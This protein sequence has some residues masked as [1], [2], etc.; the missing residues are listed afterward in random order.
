MKPTRNKRRESF[1]RL[2]ILA[3]ASVAAPVLVSADACAP[4]EIQRP[5][6]HCVVRVLSVGDALTEPYLAVDPDDPDVMA[7][8][9]NTLDATMMDAPTEWRIRPDAYVTWDG[10][11]SWF[12]TRL[13]H[14][15][16]DP[17]LA[18]N[19]GV[20]HYVHNDCPGTLANVLLGAVSPDFE[21]DIRIVDDVSH[22]R[23]R[24]FERHVV[25][26]PL[27]DGAWTDRPWLT[28]GDDGTL[29]VSGRS[30]GATGDISWSRDEG[31]TWQRLP[32]G[33]RPD[34]CRSMSPV[35]P[36]LLLFACVTRSTN[37]VRVWRID[38]TSAT[39]ARVADVE[40]LD[41]VIA[42]EIAFNIVRAAGGLVIVVDS[43]ESET[44]LLARSEDGGATWG[45]ATDLSDHLANRSGWTHFV[46]RWMAAGPDGALHLL[47]EFEAATRPL[48]YYDQGDGYPDTTGV[49][50]V[51]LDPITLEVR[52]ERILES[53]DPAEKW[54]DVPGGPTAWLAL[55][56]DAWG[57]AFN[58]TR[59]VLAYQRNGGIDV[60]R[61]IG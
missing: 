11:S 20:L 50:Y 60:F 22:D 43:R 23:G 35:E 48:A 18:F 44:V 24:T 47:L 17:T 45:P 16:G 13:M 14:S 41:D 36:S 27:A 46:K 9:T 57:I 61:G 5:A 34:D 4:E 42:N 55:A 2:L 30:T 49:A 29:F 33:A 6:G 53:G 25:A 51:V 39:V 58:G 19:H 15:G 10:G 54:N 38:P 56:D 32:Q 59:P 7:L 52:S 26:E 8:G 21:C 3:L 12:R 28:V 1:S 37:A 31:V 40:Q